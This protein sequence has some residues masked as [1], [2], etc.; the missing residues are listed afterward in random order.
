MC[1]NSY[2]VVNV[3]PLYRGVCDTLEYVAV[4][5]RAVPPPPLPPPP[6]PPPPQGKV[7]A[8]MFYEPS[9]RTSSSFQAAM[10]RLGGGVVCMSQQGSSATKGESLEGGWW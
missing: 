3:V 10:V 9:T 7:L 1:Y 2:A 4:L 6:L 8:V 5:S